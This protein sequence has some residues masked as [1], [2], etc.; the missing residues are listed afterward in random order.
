M[1]GTH[2]GERPSYDWVVVKAI[3]VPNGNLDPWYFAQRFEQGKIDP[4]MFYSYPAR[5]DGSD[6]RDPEVIH[7]KG[8]PEDLGN[9]WPQDSLPDTAP[10]TRDRILA[11]DG[12]PCYDGDCIF[13]PPTLEE[14]C[15]F[16]IAI[17]ERV[18][19][20]NQE[21]NMTRHT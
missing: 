20:H 4:R 12:P 13:V 10:I 21:L 19:K 5:F 3:G 11:Y 15:R 14:F 17:H 2:M 9:R 7:C 1:T 6:E 16:A 18:K 8:S